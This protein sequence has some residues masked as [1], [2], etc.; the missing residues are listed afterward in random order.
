[1]LGFP[2]FLTSLSLGEFH[3]FLGLQMSKISPQQ[4]SGK[5]GG[6]QAVGGAVAT[7]P[8]FAPHT[9]AIKL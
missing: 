3:Y 7:I 8:L 5:G 4:V 2:P 6:R 9:K 1:M